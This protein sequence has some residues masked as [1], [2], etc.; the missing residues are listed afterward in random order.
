M[1]NQV[2]PFSKYFENWLYDKKG[3]YSQYKTIGKDGDFYTS[4]SASS[5]FGGSIGKRVV[6]IIEEGFLD[7]DTTIVEIGA[8]HG[9]LLADMIQFIFTLKPN[10]ITTL[11][12]AIIEKYEHLRN[13]Q[14][15]YFN[16]CFGDRIKL[17]H[18]ND[19]SEIKLESAFI[20]ANE[21]FD[22]FPCELVLTNK[23]NC[24]QKAI[25][26]NHKISFTNITSKDEKIVHHCDKYNIIKGEVAVGY[27]NFILQL[28]KNIKHFEFITFDYG[29]KYPRNDFSCR[30]YKDHSVLPLFDENIHLADLYQKSDITYDVNFQHIIDIFE[31]QDIKHIAY[32]TQL[33]ALVDFGIIELLEMLHKNTN[34]KTYLAEANKIKT[35]LNPTGMGDRFKMVSFRTQ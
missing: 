11:Q 24:L 7:K 3:Y 20:V 22:A 35:L 10:L 29:E 33:Q 4:V 12:F 19:I 25:I 1:Q 34:E 14:I 15:N 27:E 30:I 21:I 2:I 32:K 31:N 6:D 18:F 9:Y 5:F 26:E 16:E 28:S 8:H 17:V 13:K 23:N